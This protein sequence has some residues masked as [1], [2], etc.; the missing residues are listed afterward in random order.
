MIEISNP[1]SPPDL[2]K[3][4]SFFICNY[5][6]YFLG[7]TY[8]EDENYVHVVISSKKFDNLPVNERIVNIFSLIKTKLPDILDS[9][10]LVV[11]AYSLNEIED[12][13]EYYV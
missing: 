8:V 13:L 1:K 2:A 6:P 3:L 7:I 9:T 12:L 4:E 11:E 10:I 5:I